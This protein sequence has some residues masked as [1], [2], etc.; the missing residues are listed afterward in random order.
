MEDLIVLPGLFVYQSMCNIK[1]TTM[2]NLSLPIFPLEVFLLPAGKVRLRVFEAKYIKL[3]SIASAKGG[4]IIQPH[5]DDEGPDNFSIGSLV[6]VHDFNQGEDGILEVDVYCRSLVGI[7]SFK[8]NDDLIFGTI[9]P[10]AHWSEEYMVLGSLP[11]EL[12]S[13]LDEIITEDIML[14]DLYQDKSLT[15]EAW[16]IARWLELLPINF[17]LKKSF[18]NDN[19][20][21][22]AKEFIESVVYK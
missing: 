11:S 7:H 6:E 4:F 3:I 16:V 2:N 1:E 13:T 19:D 12:A 5:S 15:N 14:S 17:T 10:L 20:F 21:K 18:I 8:S 22:Y 9:A